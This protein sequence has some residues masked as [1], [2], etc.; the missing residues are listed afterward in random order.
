MATVSLGHAKAQLFRALGHPVRVQILELLDDGP[1]PIGQLATALGIQ[2][3]RLSQ[4]LAILRCAVVVS[5][6]RVDGQVMYALSTRDV[7][8]LLAAARRSLDVTWSVRDSQQAGLRVS[9]VAP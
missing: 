3:L 9:V 1:Q 7:S 6:E 2:P 8:R 5:S 4:H